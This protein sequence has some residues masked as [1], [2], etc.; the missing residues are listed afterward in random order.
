M[1]SSQNVPL[2]LISLEWWN[3]Q[4]KEI[5]K[6]MKLSALWGSLSGFVP[7]ANNNHLFYRSIYLK[8][9]ANR[10]FSI[11]GKFH[12]TKKRQNLINKYENRFTFKLSIL[13]LCSYVPI[14]IDGIL[15]CWAE[16]FKMLMKCIEF[17]R[18]LI[19][20]LETIYIFSPCLFEIASKSIDS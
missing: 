15:E 14:H 13:L 1:R 12:R 5:P 19:T 11:E 10:C 17:T 2:A 9:F 16:L 7:K 20:K 4:T 18:M 8:S 3:R 6:V